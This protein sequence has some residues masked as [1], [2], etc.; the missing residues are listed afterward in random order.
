MKV[1]AKILGRETTMRLL[2]QIVPEAE[3]QLAEAQLKGAQDLAER[4]KQRAPGDGQY[5]ASIK[6]DKL[7]NRPGQKALG[8]GLKNETK[9]P[10]A[11]G[12]F[13]DHIWRWLE[14]GTQVRKTKAGANRGEGPAIPHIFPTYRANKARIRRSM[15]A[16]VRKAVRSVK[17]K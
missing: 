17:T 1:R 12:V 4:I 13:A 16:A 7:S 5:R 3:K 6:A 10:N 14:Y 9:D 8:K 15:A 2:N 11:T